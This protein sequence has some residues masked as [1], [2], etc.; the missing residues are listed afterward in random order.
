VGLGIFGEIEKAP[1]FS[2]SFLVLFDLLFE[3]YHWTWKSAVLRA[4]VPWTT[5]NWLPFPKPL[6]KDA[7]LLKSR[8]YLGSRKT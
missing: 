7:I 6:T 2:W 5:A 8:K 1:G 3:S 4:G